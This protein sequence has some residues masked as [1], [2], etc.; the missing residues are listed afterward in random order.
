MN[1]DQIKVWVKAGG[2]CLGALL[3]MKG[4]CYASLEE[5]VTKASKLLLGD[6]AAIVVGGGMAIGG[7][8]SIVSGNIMKGVAQFGV[9]ALIGVGVAITKNQSIFSVLQ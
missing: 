4:I 6:I 7:G 1:K 9:G 5:Q 2:Y 8:Y 3:M